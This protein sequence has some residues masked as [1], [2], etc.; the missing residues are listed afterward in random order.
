LREARAAARLN[1]PHI[2]AVYDVLETAGGVEIV[3]EYVRGIT[4]AA[5]LREG[6]SSPMQVLDVGLQL[7]GALAHAHA[8]G[9][10]HRDLKPANVVISPDGAA[11][12][13]DFGLALV[14]GV[15]SERVA[16]SLPRSLSFL[17]AVGTPPYMPP[18]HLMGGPAD[19]RGDIY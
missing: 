19:A 9:V 1:H 4:L 6:P 5:R 2:A 10:I 11:K 8:L 17:R 13:L 7:G 14:E 15:E 16:I 18:E 12:I 3:M